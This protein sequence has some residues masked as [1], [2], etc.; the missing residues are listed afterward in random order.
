MGRG[1]AFTGLGLRGA[2][3]RGVH[4]G[5]RQ[6][7]PSS[8]VHAVEGPMQATAPAELGTSPSSPTSRLPLREGFSLISGE[9]RSAASCCP[10]G[11][12]PASGGIITQLL[13]LYLHLQVRFFGPSKHAGLASS[14]HLESGDLLAFQSMITEL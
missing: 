12:L 1:A 7:K 6:Q 11:Q 8:N 5:G 10:S 9:L 2:Q 13:L 14:P 3:E 4:T